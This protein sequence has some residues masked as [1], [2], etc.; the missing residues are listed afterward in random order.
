[1]GKR[2]C[3]VLPVEL[4]EIGQSGNTFHDLKILSALC[5][6]EGPGILFSIESIVLMNRC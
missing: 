4:A 1:M 5:S 2:R 3:K 6:Q